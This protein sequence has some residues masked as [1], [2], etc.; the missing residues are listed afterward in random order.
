ML[1][2]IFWER[3]LEKSDYT[4]ARRLYYNFTWDLR[5]KTEVRNMN[6]ITFYSSTL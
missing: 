1:I 4:M 5:K 2:G 6:N 3:D